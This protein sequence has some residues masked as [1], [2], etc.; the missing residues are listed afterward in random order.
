MFEEEMDQKTYHLFI[1]Q[2][3]ETDEEY[4]RF[5]GR[6]EDAHDFNYENHSDNSLSGT[7]D[8]DALKT[9]IKGQITDA[10][11]VIVLS[12]LYPTYKNLIMTVLNLAQELEKPVLLI[13]P[14]GMENVPEELEKLSNGVIGWSASCIAASI[15]SLLNDEVDEYCEF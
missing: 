13:R 8:M 10:D 5:T 9:V 4:R 15:K 12:R 1:T 7:A 3:S 2:V 6:L 11:Q 14:Y